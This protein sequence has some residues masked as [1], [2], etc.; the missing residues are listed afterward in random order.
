MREQTVQICF[1]LDCTASMQPWIDA[2]KERIVDTIQTIRTSHPT[3]QIQVGFVGYRDFHD[4]THIIRIPFTTDVQ[5]LQDSIMDVVAEGGDDTCEDVAGAYRFVNTFQWYGDVRCV[6]HI[7]DAPNHGLD[8]HEET[9]DD[10]YPDGHPYIDLN[11]EVVEFA[12]KDIDLSVFR[13]KRDTDMM[14]RIMK[15]IYQT[16]RP[17]GFSIVNLR[18]RRYVA[19]D[20]FQSE[21]SQ[22][23][24][25]SM[26]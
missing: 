22:R 5:M 25:S 13:I 9:V 16:I 8:Y 26:R 6:F 20:V 18:N 15:N 17:E 3:C 7:A 10:N 14:Y 24:L 1:I 4:S 2:A 11:T 19:S 23:V 21:V 12:D